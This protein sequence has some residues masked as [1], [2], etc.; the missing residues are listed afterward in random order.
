MNKSILQKA[1]LSLN[2][3]QLELDEL[4]HYENVIEKDI[5]IKLDSGEIATFPAFRVQHNSSRGPYKGGI[6]FHPQVN[7][8]EVKI[9]SSLMTWKCAIV[10]I[11][12]GGSKGG[13]TVD[14]KQL[15]KNEQEKLSRG[16]IRAFFNHLGPDKDIPAPDIN[17]NEQNMAW[18][19]DEYSRLAGYEAPGC[20]TGKPIDLFGSKVRDIATSLGGKHVVDRLL[21]SLS[22][23]SYPIRVA[24]QGVGKVGGGLIKLLA[25]DDKYKVVAISD[26]KGGIYQAE[27]LDINNILAHKN[28]T[29]SIQNQNISN[30]ELLELGVDLLVL[31][32]LEDQITDDNAS[33]IKAKTILELANNPITEAA[34]EILEAMDVVVIPD[35]LANA[36]GVTVSYFE[37]IQNNANEYWSEDKVRDELKQV[38][39]QA[40]IGVMNIVQAQ[41]VSWRLAAYIVAL[42]RVN[43]TM[44]L[45]E[46]IV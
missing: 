32:A 45:R 30:P 36:G 18:M 46:V 11:P 41:G 25:E 2:L 28:Q 27:G 10:N 14:Y 15:S 23:D 31:A 38:M 7:L 1:A 26:S 35:I 34:D 4:L 12:M 19:M 6:R 5:E 17:T 21:K 37:W 8:E 3:S 22:L 9:L 33:N 29:G 39:R 40:T 20:V 43:Q 13:V 44:R 24:I 42:D 16:Y